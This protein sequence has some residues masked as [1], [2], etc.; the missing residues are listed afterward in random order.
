MN[1]KYSLLSED[2]FTNLT[3][4]SIEQEHVNKINSDGGMRN[5]NS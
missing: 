1:K 5:Y 2:Q 3:T 4:F